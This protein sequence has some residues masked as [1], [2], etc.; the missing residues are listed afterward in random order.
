MK[1]LVTAAT[2][3]TASL[4]SSCAY[5]PGTPTPGEQP[6]GAPGWAGQAPEPS[7]DSVL[8]SPNGCRVRY[9]DN[10]GRY[11]I[12]LFPG[13]RYRF[14]SISQNETMADSTEG[15]WT[16]HRTGFNQGELGIGGDDWALRFVSSRRAEAATPGDV[17]TYNFSFEPL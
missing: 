11:T 6:P 3:I 14:V 5:D 2:L 12:T 7:F 4:L 10:H 9:Q 16:W 13:G 1:S 8:D 15:R 17:R